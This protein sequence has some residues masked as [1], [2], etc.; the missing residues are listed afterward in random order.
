MLFLLTIWFGVRLVLVSIS[1]RDE[2]IS[3]RDFK[4]EIV[5][6][7]LQSNDTIV[8]TLGFWNPLGRE[9]KILSES[10]RVE[11]DGYPIAIHHLDFSTSP[12]VI[13]GFS[14]STRD[15]PIES[16]KIRDYAG[17]EIEIQVHAQVKIQVNIL[18]IR[19]EDT[20]ATNLLVH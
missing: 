12:L 9:I 19:M 11:Y 10:I 14:E 7:R 5:D 4:F 2:V 16:R 1:Y 6:A 8:I 20:Y 13:D 17:K 3:I 15:I 18:S